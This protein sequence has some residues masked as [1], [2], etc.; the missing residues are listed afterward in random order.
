MDSRILC[1]GEAIVDMLPCQSADGHLAYRPVPGGAPFNTACALAS[2]GIPTGF[3]GG[4]SNDRLGAC[5][6]DRAKDQSVSLSEAFIS[7]APSTL[8]FVHPTERG[9]SYTF[10]MEG[11]ASATYDIANLP[12]L[13]AQT[14][15]LLFGGVSLIGARSGAAYERL[16]ETAQ[17]RLVY[18]DVNIRPALIP[19]N[20]QDYR[21]R[22]SRMFA[23][24]DVIKVSDDDLDWIG[25]LPD[26]RAEQLVL[27]TRGSEGVEARQHGQTHHIPARPAKVVDT[28][29]AGDMFNAAFLAR[30]QETDLTARLHFACTAASL[31]TEQ[32]GAAA[33]TIEEIECAL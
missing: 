22:L 28:V 33:L 30:D 25:T 24:A 29:G 23:L 17:D 18:L 15:A 27:V 3:V 4:L 20:D 1:C 5:L 8:A 16:A 21:A 10:V 14:R 7:D 6:I 2:I 32:A 13:S 9:E 26:M 11:T 31:S 12:S 19:A